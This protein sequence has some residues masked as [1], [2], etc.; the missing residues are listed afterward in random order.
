VL[1]FKLDEENFYRKWLKHVSHDPHEEVLWFVDENNN[2]HLYI[3]SHDRAYVHR[4]LKTKL[5]ERFKTSNMIT[6]R[7]AVLGLDFPEPTSASESSLGR[8]LRNLFISK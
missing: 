2:I 8:S 1:V 6:A 7:G 4:V 5:S 3:I